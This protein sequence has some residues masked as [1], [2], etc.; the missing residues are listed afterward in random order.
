MASSI[1]SSINTASGSTADA[2]SSAMTSDLFD[3]WEPNENYLKN[4][5]NFVVWP[6]LIAL[7]LTIIFQLYYSSVQYRF[8]LQQ[9]E[10]IEKEKNKDKYGD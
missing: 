10:K 2:V 1:N 6:K 7:V 4:C 9:K 8:Y 3:N 5:D